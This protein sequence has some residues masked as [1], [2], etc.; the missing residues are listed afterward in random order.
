MNPLRSIDRFFHGSSEN[1]AGYAAI[2]IFYVINSLLFLFS[3]RPL[4][5]FFYGEASFCPLP[6][7][8]WLFWNHHGQF[9]FFQMMGTTNAVSIIW[10]L[11][12]V[13]TLFIMIGYKIRVVMLLQF[14]FLSSFFLT[15]CHPDNYGDQIFLAT[16]FLLIFLPGR[17]PLS[18][19]GRNHPPR[20][21][22]PWLR[23]TLM[24]FLC[25]IYLSSALPRW[26]GIHWWDGTAVWI[27][28][29]DPA[30]SRIWIGLEAWQSRVPA[31]LFNG[32][33]WT[34]TWLSLGY[35]LSFSLLVWIR[36]LRTPLVLIGLG[37]HMC[38]GIVLDLG[39]FSMHISLLLIACLD[40]NAWH[41][42]MKGLSRSGRMQSRPPD[43][44]TPDPETVTQQ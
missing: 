39:L 29:I 43:Q 28:L 18:I 7:T 41:N 6:Q 36:R 31:V 38:L 21:Y 19:D 23:K 42:V 13:N 34:L 32:I 2:R 9:S 17:D 37:F 33:I 40:D 16:A 10:A 22:S 44:A 25:T 8:G 5:S 15:P 35:E 3:I 24:L 12:L 30:N 20:T 26:S 27:S 4:L 1:G 11:T 14:L